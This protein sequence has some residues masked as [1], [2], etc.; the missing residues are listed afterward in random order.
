MIIVLLFLIFVVTDF[1][2][3]RNTNFTNLRILVFV[4]VL[5]EIRIIL[6]YEY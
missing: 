3:L 2:F 6:I 4:F 5:Y 1:L